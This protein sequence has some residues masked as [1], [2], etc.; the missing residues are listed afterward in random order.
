MQQPYQLRVIL[1]VNEHPLLTAQ[2]INQ[3]R[4]EIRDALQRDLGA[5]GQ[6]QSSCMI[7]PIPKKMLT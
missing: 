6:V 1:Q 4:E 2:Y 3:I 5:T 7:R